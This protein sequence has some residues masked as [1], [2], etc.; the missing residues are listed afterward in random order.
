MTPE[1]MFRRREQQARVLADLLDHLGIAPGDQVLDVGCGPGYASLLAAE[2]TG[3]GGCVWAVDVWTEALAYLRDRCAERGIGWV[4]TVAGDAASFQFT[5]PA[6]RIDRVLV[7]DMLHHAADPEGI[8]RHL[9][10][11]LPAGAR[12]VVCDY[13]PVAEKRFGPD[14]AMRIPEARMQ[15]WLVAAGFAIVAAWRPPDEHYAFLIE[16]EG[17]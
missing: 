17:R 14:P 9:A 15:A 13:A 5:P 7:V 12:G 2:R 11:M 6:P 1:R 10:G 8:V 3:P 4:R 16:R